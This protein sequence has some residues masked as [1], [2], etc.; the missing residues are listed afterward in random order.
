MPILA[1]LL[2]AAFW[3]IVTVHG[4]IVYQSKKPLTGDACVE[5]MAFWIVRAQQMAARGEPVVVDGRF[6]T[7]SDVS[8]ECLPGERA[9]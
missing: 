9:S 5:Q 7:I 4:D 8:I 6:V 1:A 2:A 3:L